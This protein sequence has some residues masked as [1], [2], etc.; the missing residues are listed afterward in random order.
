MGDL[1]GL[2]CVIS[3]WWVFGLG[4]C[5]FF[6]FWLWVWCFGERV[7]HVIFMGGGC[8]SQSVRQRDRQTIRQTHNE[9]DRQGDRQ[10]NRQTII[11]WIAEHV[12]HIFGQINGNIWNCEWLNE[13]RHRQRKA[14][15]SK[16]T[17]HYIWKHGN[18]KAVRQLERGIR[19]QMDKQPV[20]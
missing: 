12:L 20:R 16:K 10:R 11:C 6:G 2:V 17:S 15:R 4:G 1:D 19:N 9:T 18:R 8:V 3:D 14:H 7:F 13:S 5:G